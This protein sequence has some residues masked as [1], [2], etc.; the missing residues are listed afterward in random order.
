MIHPY[1]TCEEALELGIE[2]SLKEYIKIVGRS[3]W[4][5]IG[6]FIELVGIISGASGNNILLPYWVLASIGIIALIVAQFLAYH[7]VR[8]QRDEA[9]SEVGSAISVLESEN[10]RVSGKYISM[11]GLFWSMG[12]YFLKVIDPDSVWSVIHVIFKSN[13]CV[14]S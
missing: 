11:A 8:T 12:R 9:R 10:I 13:G 3:W 7:K 1:I 2:Q 6:F 4:G 5:I 14:S